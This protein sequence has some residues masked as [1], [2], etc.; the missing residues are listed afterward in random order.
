MSETSELTAAIKKL[1]EKQTKIV[2]LPW[3]FYRGMI[4]GLGFFVGG[5]LLVGFLLYLMS[6]FDTA[7]VVGDYISKILH[8]INSTK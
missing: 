3:N 6:M 1:D 8:V 2:S 5:T 4:Y 7:P